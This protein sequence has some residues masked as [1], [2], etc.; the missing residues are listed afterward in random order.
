MTMGESRRKEVSFQDMEHEVSKATSTSFKTIDKSHTK[1]IPFKTIDKSGTNRVSFK[2]IE[3]TNN[4]SIH[5]KTF[6]EWVKDP[7][8]DLP[9]KVPTA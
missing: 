9:P 7:E 6:E 2:T 4:K 8:V 3:E 5:F 1:Q